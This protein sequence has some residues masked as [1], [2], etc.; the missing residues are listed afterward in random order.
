MWF[1]QQI[2]TA[3]LQ[4]CYEKRG[5]ERG[6]LFEIPGALHNSCLYCQTPEAYQR[7][8]SSVLCAVQTARHSLA[9]RSFQPGCEISAGAWVWPGIAGGGE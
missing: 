8:K 1:A 5:N 7:V 9:A 3:H 6:Q 4:N 2:F